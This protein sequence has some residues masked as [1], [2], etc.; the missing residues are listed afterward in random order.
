[1]H[2]NWDP[3]GSLTPGIRMLAIDC[4]S[5]SRA[6]VVDIADDQNGL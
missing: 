3:E 5:G 1:M 6:I 2:A 4:A